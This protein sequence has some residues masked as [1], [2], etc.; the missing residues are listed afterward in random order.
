M[1]T[2]HFYPERTLAYQGVNS[3]KVQYEG[4]KAAHEADLSAVESCF[5]KCHVSTND[6]KINERENV[7]LSK[8]YI[9]YFDSA[10]L[11]EKETK[12]YVHG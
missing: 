11:I 8:C 12:H 1:Q 6:A 7:C 4:V 5:G 9:R 3:F 2:E 10:L